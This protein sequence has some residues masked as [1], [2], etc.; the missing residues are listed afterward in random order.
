M[1]L[2]C[3]AKGLCVTWSIVYRGEVLVS[4]QLPP[5]SSCSLLRCL[6]LQS[7]S[8]WSEA[9]QAKLRH[10]WT[11]GCQRS[12]RPFLS[13]F[14]FHHLS[15]PG[16]LCNLLPYLPSSLNPSTSVPLLPPCFLSLADS[17]VFFF[18]EDEGFELSPWVPK[19]SITVLSRREAVGG[20]VVPG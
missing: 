9:T 12:R 17:T 11:L 6:C 19:T 15:L 2:C 14:S 3:P 16:T 5:C 4:K 1:G 18:G 20:V 13:P 10:M 7:P 8:P